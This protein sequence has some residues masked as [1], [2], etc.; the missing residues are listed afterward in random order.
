MKNN[1]CRIATSLVA[2]GF[3]AMAGAQSINQESSANRLSIE[4]HVPRGLQGAVKPQQIRAA[5]AAL[6]ANRGGG[7]TGGLNISTQSYNGF[8]LSPSLPFWTFN[9][10]GSRDGD[11]HAGVMVGGDPFIN[12][13][14][15]S[16]PTYIVPLIFRTHTVA[17]GIDANPAD[18][19]YGQYTTK[20]GVTMIDPTKPD[21]NKCLARPNNVPIKVI[22]QSPIVNPAKFVFGGTDVGTTQY[23][24]AFQ[25][26][27]FWNVLGNAGRQNYHVLLGPVITLSPVVIDV[28]ATAGMAVTDPNFYEAAFGFSFCA[29]IQFVDI[30]W[31]DS[32]LTGTVLPALAE[33]GVGPT[34]FPVFIS[35]NA[36]WPIGD[37]T[38]IFNCC[39]A[40]YHSDTGVPILNQTYG[41]ADF[42]T[43][44]WFE[45]PAN[46]LLTSDLSHEVAE[47]MNDPFG[48]N[49]TAPWGDTGQVSGCQAN[50]EVGDPLTGSDVAPVTMPNGFTYSL[51][52]LAFFSWFFGAPSIGVNGWFSDNGTFTTDAGPN[53]PTS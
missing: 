11:H 38:S 35:Y 22:Q 24:D 46:G 2:L 10:L 37:V 9:V 12:P 28:P 36:A 49:E 27:N 45:G 14:S 20:P 26:A 25:R 3:M 53:C 40:G 19:T 34:T 52:E 33:Q 17:T 31:F 39:A 30:N 15:T 18:A 7:N 44:G 23:V 4:V 29:P 47:W 41:V 42:D 48:S 13:A 21:A 32:Y 51:Q 16:I 50:L 6:N 43:T 1:P 5:Y 8:Y